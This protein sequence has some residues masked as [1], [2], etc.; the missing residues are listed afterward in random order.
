MNEDP[1]QLKRDFI[2]LLFYFLIKS[3]GVGLFFVKKN[4]T[5]FEFC[6]PIK[7]LNNILKTTKNIFKCNVKKQ[8]HFHFNVE[9][10]NR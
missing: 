8:K 6:V 1:L 3:T 4:S 5:N 7:I 2:H 9:V 10:E